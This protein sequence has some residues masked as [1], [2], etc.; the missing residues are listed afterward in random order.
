M[1]GYQLAVD[2]VLDNMP[3]SQMYNKQHKP[4]SD[5]ERYLSTEI[6]QRRR[7]GVGELSDCY[8][9]IEWCRT[10][11]DNMTWSKQKYFYKIGHKLM[12]D[13]NSYE[14]LNPDV[15][16]EVYNCALEKTIE[17]SN[18]NLVERVILFIK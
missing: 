4:S 8:K 18:K 6:R 11:A 10:T 3:P 2:K 5:S 7:K 12:N 15:N 13:Y 9:D 14:W 17:F 1:T 16:L